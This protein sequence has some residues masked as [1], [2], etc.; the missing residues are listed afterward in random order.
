MSKEWI[1]FDP[2]KI[3]AVASTM[4]TQHKEIRKGTDEIQNRAVSTSEF[5]GGASQELYLEEME[6]LHRVGT[7]LAEVL[8][9]LVTDL[10]EA[11]GIYKKGEASAKQQA[12]KLPTDVFLV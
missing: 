3:L 6:E 12:E 11:S 4:K 2:E 8:L 10:E 9:E 7:E 5:W 1:K